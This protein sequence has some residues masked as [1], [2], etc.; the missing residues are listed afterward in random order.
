METD[1]S[2]SLEITPED[3]Q[4]VIAWS[5]TQRKKIDRLLRRRRIQAWPDNIKKESDFYAALF[6]CLNGPYGSRLINLLARFAEK[7]PRVKKASY[8]LLTRL[9]LNGKKKLN[10]VTPEIS[11][12]VSYDPLND[13]RDHFFDQLEEIGCGVYRNVWEWLTN[14]MENEKGTE[15]EEEE[16]QNENIQGNGYMEMWCRQKDELVLLSEVVTTSITRAS[17]GLSVD[18]QEIGEQITELIEKGQHLR[19]EIIERA[20]ALELDDVSWEDWE[21]FEVVVDMIQQ[22]ANRLREQ[23]ITS[24]RELLSSL[25]E[26]FEHVRIH[27]RSPRTVE[28]L[29]QVVENIKKELQ[30]QLQAEELVRSLPGPVTAEAWIDW[31]FS[32]SG[33]EL[34]DVQQSIETD[35]PALAD[36]IGE[37]EREWIQVTTK[38]IDNNQQ[39]SRQK[40]AAQ[41]ESNK[42]SADNKPVPH[43]EVIEEKELETVDGDRRASPSTILD[44]RQELL[45]E[46]AD[47]AVTSASS[48]SITEEPQ[49][50]LLEKQDN[51][52]DSVSTPQ[53]KEQKSSDLRSIT[54]VKEAD[55]LFKT[56][57]R[58]G[59]YSKAYW[60]SMCNPT[61]IPSELVGA[62]ALGVQVR[63]GAN[64]SGQLQTFFSKL[65]EIEATEF[66]S[67][68]LILTSILGSALFMKPIPNKIYTLIEMT[69]SGI[70]PIDA[71]AQYVKKEFIYKNI[72]LH[73]VDIDSAL[74]AEE[75][76]AK[77]QQLEIRSIELRERNRQADAIN[78]APGRIFLRHLYRDGSDLS[79]LHAIVEKNKTDQKSEVNAILRDIVPEELVNNAHTMGIKKCANPITGTA[80]DQLVR[81][82]ND[83]LSL[84]REWYSIA[85]S[86]QS[87]EESEQKKTLLSRLQLFLQKAIDSITALPAR[88][89]PEPIA[90]A[91]RH[92]LYV[93]QATLKGDPPEPMELHDVLLALPDISLD[94]DF[95]PTTDSHALAKALKNMTSVTL[96]TED[97]CRRLLDRK[98]FLRVETLIE[99]KSLDSN[100]IDY[101]EQEVDNSRRELEHRIELL[102]NRVEDAYLQG[103]LSPDFFLDSSN[104]D[105]D[106]KLSQDALRSKMIGELEQI[107]KRLTSRGKPFRRFRGLEEAVDQIES[108]LN[109]M[110]QKQ[111]RELQDE[112]TRLLPRFPNTEDG[113]EDRAYL[114]EAFEKAIDKDDNIAAAELINRAKEAIQNN[115]RLPRTTLGENSELCFFLEQLDGY[116]KLLG[117]KSKLPTYIKGIESRK[118]IGGIR[119]SRHDK[120]HRAAVVEGL[121]AWS[122]LLTLNL[123]ANQAKNVLIQEAR[124]VLE[125]FDIKTK[126]LS[127]PPKATIDGDFIYLQAELQYPLT[128]C[129]IPTFGSA[130]GKTMHVILAP[131]KKEPQQLENFLNQNNLNHQPILLIY[132]QEMGIAL[133]RK[134]QQ[135]C[136][137]KKRSV[138]LV[139]LC[140]AFYLTKARNR[141]PVLFNVALPFS[142]AQPYLMKG[143]NVP[144]ETFVGRDSEVQSIVDPQGACIVFGG[145][146]LGK[147][148]LLRHVYKNFNA[149]AEGRFVLYMD[150]DVLGMA[151][152]THEQMRLDFWR[153]LHTQLIRENF[154]PNKPIAARKAEKVEDEV[155]DK[156]QRVLGETHSGHL[157]ILLDEADSFLDKDSSFN[158]PIVRRLRA[159]M[160][161]TERRFKVVLAGLQ[162][163]QRYKNW[164]NHP[165][166]QLGSDIAVRPLTPAAAQN[167][168]LAPLQALGFKFQERR[169]ILR[170]LS[171][172]NYH[173]GLI[174]IFCYRLLENLYKRWSQRSAEDP[175]KVILLEDLQGVERNAEF[176]EDIRNRFDWTL[177]LDD[178]YKVLVYSLVLTSDPASSRDEREFMTLAREWWPQVFEKM[179]QQAL[180]AVLDELEGLGVLV[181]EDT[182]H[183][184]RY[185][186]RSPNLL[187]LLGTATQIEDELERIISRQAPT[188]LNPR[189]FHPKMNMD[190]LV[191]FGPL[192]KEQEGQLAL[193][194]EGHFGI[195][196]LMGSE[197]LGLDQTSPQLE[198]IFKGL[199][200]WQKLNLPPQQ[201]TAAR[202]TV[203]Y[204][205]ELFK[206]RR[207]HHLF[208]L[209]DTALLPIEFDL[210]AFC[211][212]LL[213][214]VARVCT[215]RSRG[216]VVLLTT[217]EFAWRWLDEAKE[218]VVNDQRIQIIELRRWSDGAISNALE[219]IGVLTGAKRLG[220]DLFNITLGWPVLVQKGLEKS[221]NAS[222]DKLIDIWNSERKQLTADFHR[223]PEMFLKCFGLHTD[224]DPLNQVVKH[225][226][227]WSLTDDTMCIGSDTLECVSEDLKHEGLK[228]LTRKRW[229]DI[230]NWLRMMDLVQP[231]P[232]EK[233]VWQLNELVGSIIAGQQ[234]E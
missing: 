5:P 20:H 8:F 57:L 206:P 222:P 178:R 215:K 112:L 65:V 115:S 50:P 28:R 117:V 14:I 63:P 217:P 92:G 64:I 104:G 128:C 23:E 51:I 213:N 163:V 49:K 146:Q 225:I 31:A 60:L 209:F 85:C 233:N 80:R 69:S 218:T 201:I 12:E 133:R 16:Q 152:Q 162:S 154:L 93:L 137:G 156:I 53:E 19:Q 189:N 58:Q 221:S 166:A 45:P 37:C 9:L 56:F 72:V 100:C 33:N 150:I 118:T 36:F 208:C 68:L 21:Q 191:Q 230:L 177:D 44:K 226:L 96:I 205:K 126:S 171:Q 4:E 223:E 219:N 131:T 231:F 141:L 94:D 42:R 62:L 155:I 35:L 148:A 10:K 142:W 40:S 210:T 211:V 103:N 151:P 67:R 122:R 90:T 170:I 196:L 66:S 158:F 169:L 164:K 61:T 125:F 203:E 73:P 176:I 157:Y 139:D 79:L 204:L 75:V 88:D 102:S 71:L 29:Q 30:R 91:C 54:G 153:K 18:N 97:D 132:L 109:H 174:Q 144:L 161:E 83:T 175:P 6:E 190:K 114:R 194:A 116:Q 48:V 188:I 26:V 214:Q 195:T 200:D 82:I 220:E 86:Q 186:L 3:L 111:N 22:E 7:Q 98:E 199:A 167:L 84:A 232:T 184:R 1:H 70:Q 207:R 123:S 39:P 52:K 182:D 32:L 193:A 13:D 121:T 160:A 135:Y 74:G 197:A 228:F 77:L 34:E 119:F 172:A 27:H 108:Q 78:Y 147:S 130:M 180:R 124:K 216:H 55:D 136:A 168:I 165:F 59:E 110:E 81:R 143:E 149:P 145:R 87:Q 127:M 38:Q 185:R 105:N 183:T 95:I 113:K 41:D 99:K 24:V 76:E 227:T 15:I 106:E 138:L 234:A 129:P 11:E 101:L 25:L 192:T 173:P 120:A 159:I 107:Q 2:I 212:N 140:L 229:G 224:I 47:D 187:R 134:F 181:R 198:N 202:K 89:L 43:K 17:L 46:E 179:D